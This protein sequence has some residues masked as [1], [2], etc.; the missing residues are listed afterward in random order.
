M[1]VSLRTQHKRNNR[2]RFENAIVEF[3]IERESPIA[4]PEIMDYLRS[5]WP[6]TAPID[7]RVFAMLGSM[8][9]KG[10]IGYKWSQPGGSKRRLWFAKRVQ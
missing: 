10:L 7:R 6:K 3:L 8:H 1:M 9:K 2:K 4:G 5:Q